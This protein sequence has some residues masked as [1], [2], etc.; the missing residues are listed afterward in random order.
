MVAPD[1]WLPFIKN[2]SLVK[3][4]DLLAQ[5]L[6]PGAAIQTVE[7]FSSRQ[8]ISAPEY[9]A[10]L[11]SDERMQSEVF[12]HLPLERVERYRAKV[13]K[14][15]LYLLADTLAFRLHPSNLPS[16]GLIIKGVQP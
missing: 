7:V 3:W 6:H 13:L 8:G 1:G 12:D 15:N 16:E 11:A 2:Q 10:L 14:D 4:R 9:Y 5:Q